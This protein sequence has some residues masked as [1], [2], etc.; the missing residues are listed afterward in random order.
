MRPPIEDK[1][2]EQCVVNATDQMS[3][4]GVNGT[5]TVLIDGERMRRLPCNDGCDAV[6]AAAR[7]TD[8]EPVIPD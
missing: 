3:K 6:L 2:F 8:V 5:P 7:V 1:V 4:D